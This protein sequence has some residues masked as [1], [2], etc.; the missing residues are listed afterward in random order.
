MI[1]DNKPAGYDIDLLARFCKAYGYGME[2]Q[3]MNFDG[4]LASVQSG[5]CQIGACGI[6]ITE[7]RAESVLFSDPNFYTGSVLCVYDKDAV[8]SEG[9]FASLAASFTK[10]FF[11]ESRWKLFFR[12]IGTTL[13]ITVLSCACGTALGFLLFMACRKGNRAINVLTGKCMWLIQGMPMV[14]LLM[15]LF[16]L[17]FGKAGVS[18]TVV[19]SVGFTLILLLLSSDF[20]GSVSAPSSAGSMKPLLP[21]A[22]PTAG[23]FTRSF[24]PRR[25]RA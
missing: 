7:E 11:R 5:K 9:V 18:G 22:F 24:C 19:A 20:S 15:I 17:V 16:Y 3:S 14:V 13:F 1:K 8:P 21:L 6:T 25:F 23:R 12:G 4:I 10:T 2:I